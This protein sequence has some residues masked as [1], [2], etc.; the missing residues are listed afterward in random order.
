MSSIEL[1]GRGEAWDIKVSHKRKVNVSG[2]RYL[3]PAETDLIKQLPLDIPAK[4][5]A[6]YSADAPLI[7]AVLRALS[8]ET[9]I[10]VFTTEL[11]DLRVAGKKFPEELKINVTCAADFV[12]ESND[13]GLICFAPQKSFDRMLFFDV[14]ERLNSVLPAG[15]PVLMAFPVERLK[16]FQKKAEQ[17]LKNLQL[18]NKSRANSVYSGL[19]RG[20][21]KKK[22]WTAR[23]AKVA[24]STMNAEFTM[25]TRPGV[26]SHGRADVGGV[27][28]SEVVEVEPGQDIL[29]LGC[30][31]GLVG[32][33]L[34][35]RQRDIQ[36]DHQ[37]SVDLVDSNTRAIECC[38]KNIEI[39]EFKNCTAIG[40]D[41]YETDKTYDL[42][43]G[44]PPYFA[45]QRIGEYFIRTAEKYLRAQGSLAIVSKHGAQLAEVAD[46]LGFGT[47][48]I[49]RKG[50]DI[51][52][53]KRYS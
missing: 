21:P 35:Q 31:A 25:I 10:D 49:K 1:Q 32:L 16:D 5:L 51:S 41:V 18:V 17:E 43:V 36:A 24:V 45:G 52:I 14:L 40:A 34:A 44:N 50:Y 13:Y 48:L 26:F 28:L 7:P 22:G 8:P 9:Q 33:S 42:I 39:N 27:A 38:K 19:T 30:G 37:G 15:I 6:L 46:E 4:C 3:R 11:H 23:E 2:L 20:K 12:P 29:D 53:C 47:K